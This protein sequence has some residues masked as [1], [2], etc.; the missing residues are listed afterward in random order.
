MRDHRN[1]KRPWNR[2]PEREGVVVSPSGTDPS[3]LAGLYQEMEQLYALRDIT[4]PALTRAGDGQPFT[5]TLPA[6]P[7]APL[8]QFAVQL[9]GMA[10]SPP[11]YADKLG[12]PVGRD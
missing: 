4:L 3:V 7:D 10:D 12:L 5:I 11:R 9:E 8:D 1:M 6:D 2:T